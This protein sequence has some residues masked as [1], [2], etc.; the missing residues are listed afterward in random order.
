MTRHLR[1]S[2]LTSLFVAALGV[3]PAVRAEAEITWCGSWVQSPQ[4]IGVGLVDLGCLTVNGGSAV[5]LSPSGSPPDLNTAAL[6]IGG[7]Q[8]TPS[9]GQGTVTIDGMNS[10]IDITGQG[11]SINVGRWG[12][13]STGALT[14][15]DGGVLGSTYL[16]VGRGTIS[17]LPR[18]FFAT[19]SSGGA[20]GVWS[21][22]GNYS[23]VITTLSS[24]GES[25]PATHRTSVWVDNVTKTVTLTW[26]VPSA[27]VTGYNVYRSTN[28]GS[29]VTPALVATISSG[30]TTTYVDVGFP[31]TTGAPPMPDLE[32]GATGTVAVSGSGSAIQLGGVDT[33]GNPAG[34]TIGSQGGVGHVTLSGN[35]VMTIDG[36]RDPGETAPPATLSPYVIVGRDRVSQVK[37]G[38]DISSLRIDTGAKVTLTGNDLGGM[39]TLGL[40]PEAD[41]TLTIT[42]EGTDLRMD[43]GGL[44]CCMTI[45]RE[46]SGTLTVDAGARLTF[47]DIKTGG[48][49]L[50]YL[51]AGEGTLTIRNGGTVE[52]NGSRVWGMTVGRLGHGRLE[53]T[54]GGQLIAT[55]TSSSGGSNIIFGGSS[56][57]VTGGTFDVLISGQDSTL[58]LGG[59]DAS[60]VL[61]RMP[62]ASG[63]MTVNDR[64]TVNA[65]LFVVGRSAGSSASMNVS[66]SGTTVN[67]TGDPEGTRG[68]GFTVGEAGT[69]TMTVDLGAV[70][71]ID[72]TATSQPT[73]F[74]VGG[75]TGGTGTMT[76]SGGAQVLTDATGRSSIGSTPGSTGTVTVT[77]ASS[78]IDAGAFLGIALDRDGNPG[79]TG[80]LTVSNGGTVRA[81][82][83]RCGP[84]GRING[85]GGIIIGDVIADP[86]CVITPGSSPGT[87]SI[88]G[89]FTSLGAKIVLEV[90]ANGNHD[91]LA[92]EGTAFFDPSTEIEVR[93]DPAFQPPGGT[94]LVMVQVQRTPQH[95]VQPLLTLNVSESGGGTVQTEG[96]LTT[97]S[98]PIA[99]VPD[100]DIPATY[101]AVQIDIKPGVF[102]NVINLASAG[103]IPVAV[104]STPAF[105]A[106]SVDPVTITLDGAAVRLV[107]KGQRPL[108][109]TQD[110]NGDGR[111]DLLCHVLTSPLPAEGDAV[112]ILDAIAYPLGSPPGIP[113]R[114]ADFIKIV[115]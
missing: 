25:E 68:A 87:L 4:F 60:F 97:L 84:G 106:L 56:T 12:T 89:S 112:A 17:P 94:T 79:G 33:S 110:V 9:E 61:G 63:T 85:D 11:A 48:V 107:G 91:V 67:L 2:R 80:T 8:Y 42:G 7:N 1:Y 31:T 28:P 77:G 75:S 88:I 99:V 39:L 62:G 36:R 113:I 38:E 16:M 21:S 101:R 32:H 115:P 30:T 10:R 37:A 50:G 52:I 70:I 82:L 45:G 14:V 114:G 93:V 64:A 46:G 58:S 66:G 69:G 54:G 95:P 6:N 86:G 108:C 51:A 57:S 90:D 13:D 83:I 59:T 78:L 44:N 26:S 55:G 20:G 41:G 92:V 100:I 47:T 27:P 103:T 53:I 5:I 34:L 35:A 19:L 23:Y 76:I 29:F 40:G 65:D 49:L 18:V 3:L 72:G 71:N 22:T 96:D 24:I 109:S 73:G 98:Q 81:A 43:A 111:P 15:T 105:D 74:S 102:P 104:I